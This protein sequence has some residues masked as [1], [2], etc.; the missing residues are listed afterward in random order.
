ASP[1]AMPPQFQPPT[2]GYAPAAAVGGDYGPPPEKIEV[3]RAVKFLISD[4]VDGKTNWLYATLVQLIP[5]VGPITM[6]GWQAEITQRLARR[7]P[8]PIPKFDFGDFTHYLTRGLI[9]FLAQLIT[10]LPIIFIWYIFLFV[11]SI[12]VGII[13]GAIGSPEISMILL[14]MVSFFAYF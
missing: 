3:M 6:L 8:K 10:V 1:M 9:P 12:L 5:V 7:H 13:G 11:A 2:P 14:L 4:P